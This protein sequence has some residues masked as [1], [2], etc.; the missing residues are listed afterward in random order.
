MK[1]STEKAEYVT[2]LGSL[3]NIIHWRVNQARQS[4]KVKQ[5]NAEHYST[6]LALQYN[7]KG[8]PAA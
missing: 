4:E 8:T 6:L 2:R 3:Q 1:F 7:Y 5:R